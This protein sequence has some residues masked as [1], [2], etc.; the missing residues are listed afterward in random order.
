MNL[1]YNFSLAPLIRV[2]LYTPAP[3]PRIDI[4]IFELFTEPGETCLTINPL[5]LVIKSFK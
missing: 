4:V 5:A 3:K 2:I 1:E